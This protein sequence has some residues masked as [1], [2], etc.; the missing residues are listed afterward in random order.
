MT[1]RIK[2]P[3]TAPKTRRPAGF[4]DAQGGVLDVSDVMSL[5]SDMAIRFFVLMLLLA[6]DAVSI[7]E[8]VLPPG[9]VGY[10]DGIAWCGVS[11]GEMNP[12]ALSVNQAGYTRCIQPEAVEIF[13]STVGGLAVLLIVVVLLAW[14]QPLWRRR[15]WALAPV[16]AHSHPA[17]HADLVALVAL[18]GID[19][20][21][22]FFLDHYDARLRGQAYGRYR[23]PA[24]RLSA[25]LAASRERD[26]RTFRGIVLH[27]LAHVRNR[28][29]GLTYLTVAAWRAF[30]LAALLPLVVSM[31]D[32][33]L[34]AGHPAGLFA[35][36]N[37][38]PVTAF[39]MVILTLLVY[40]T[41]N[42]VLRAREMHADVRAA[43]WDSA[44]TDLISAA[45]RARTSKVSRRD[46]RAWAQR[47]VRRFGA[48]PDPADRIAAIEG[49]TR[50]M[51]PSWT[52]FALAT[53]ASV[54]VVEPAQSAVVLCLAAFGLDGRDGIWPFVQTA[55]LIG[56]PLAVLITL[57][58]LRTT[59]H[60]RSM[61]PRRSDAV[62]ALLAVLAG[63]L[64]APLV[65]IDNLDGAL[66]GTVFTHPAASDVSLALV[67]GAIIVIVFLAI[68]RLCAYLAPPPARIRPGHTWAPRNDFIRAPV[69]GRI[70]L[71]LQRHRTRVS[72]PT[73]A[74]VAALAT[75]CAG[76]LVATLTLGQQAT[77]NAFDLTTGGVGPSLEPALANAW[78]DHG[79]A[80]ELAAVFGAVLKATNALLDPTVEPVVACTALD[81]ADTEAMAFTGIPDYTIEM[82]WLTVLVE[83][84]KAA[85]NCLSTQP[86]YTADHD[87]VGQNIAGII[88]L[89]AAVSVLDHE[90]S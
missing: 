15:R 88:A 17:L 63:L 68:R 79:G 66:S 52:A 4:G 46:R 18:A 16:T 75:F 80:T 8:Q 45:V 62:A 43:S 82:Q 61:R 6:G 73:P 58:V 5:P 90:T 78:M 76:V 31:A 41:R 65:E 21:P 54:A 35:N 25:G 81:E 74:R 70:T 67:E 3:E 7:Y 83:T 60:P 50:L 69:G 26:P 89:V 14:A 64:L 85:E 22:E 37:E 72:L 1:A 59:G 30:V 13:A 32:V 9:A 77:Y 49:P 24:V 10:V 48:H 39:R 2:A 34:L 28:D 19:P 86:D 47:W 57:T 55:A 53:F 29:I 42:S 44:T 71:I 36:L 40:L 33:D 23:R 51:R 27:E 12:G 20:A 38:V 87:A 84:H 56:V 11:T